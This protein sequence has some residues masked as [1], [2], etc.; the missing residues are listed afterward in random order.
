MLIYKIGRPDLDAAGKIPNWLC[1][2]NGVQVTPSVEGQ[3]V[4]KGNAK[5]NNAKRFRKK[6][7]G[8]Y[9]V[10]EPVANSHDYKK[11]QVD[12]GDDEDEDEF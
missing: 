8:I 1:D 12:G 11:A 4:E 5:L 7:Q 6:R 9:M 10:L 3:K 2:E